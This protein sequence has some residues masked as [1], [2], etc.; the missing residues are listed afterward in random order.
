MVTAVKRLIVHLP[1]KTIPAVERR[2]SRETVLTVF[3]SSP[4]FA[5]ARPFEEALPVSIAFGPVDA[6]HYAAPVSVASPAPDPV[7]WGVNR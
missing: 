3:S 4:T 1:L 2:P 5:K 6:A 7:G